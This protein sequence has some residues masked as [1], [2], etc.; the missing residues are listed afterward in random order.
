VGD[1]FTYE[2]KAT[3][4]PDG[5][6]A[7]GLP[8]WLSLN[9]GTGGL[10]ATALKSGTFTFKVS[11]EN[12]AGWGPDFEV[13]L[14]V[15][16]LKSAYRT[17]GP[18]S[19]QGYVNEVLYIIPTRSGASGG[20]YVDARVDDKQFWKF[21]KEW[22][23]SGQRW[24]TLPARTGTTGFYNVFLS[25]SH[26]YGDWRRIS[27]TILS[28]QPALKITSPTVVYARAGEAFTYQLTS[29]VAAASYGF[30]FVGGS[31][32]N[33][34]FDSTTGLVSGTPSLPG[35]YSIL[36]SAFTAVGE[37]GPTSEITLVVNPAVG[38]SSITG[39]TNTGST[40]S[41][42]S[43]SKSLAFGKLTSQSFQLLGG[44]SSGATSG[45]TL[46]ATG[47]VGQAFSYT[48]QASGDV[49]QFDAEGLPPGLVL[50]PNTGEIS[51]QPSLPGD[52]EVTARAWNDAGPGGD[53]VLTITIAAAAGTP[54]VTGTL[55]ATASVDTAFI[56]TITATQSPL[57]FNAANLPPWA[58]LND[59]TGEITGIPDAPGDYE[60]IIS[61]NNAAGI[62]RSRTLALAVHAAAGTPSITS[63]PSAS[64][65]ENAS[66]TIQL[67]ASNS[68][69]LFSADTLPPG[70]LLDQENGLISGVP[71]TQGIYQ[72]HVWAQNAAGTGAAS[73]LTI[74]VG[75][76]A[77]TPLITSAAT[78]MGRVGEAFQFTLTAS[79]NPASFTVGALPDGLAID[80]IT[81]A[82]TGM[83][84]AEGTT[85]VAVR[86]TNGAG[87]GAETT[88]TIDI[89]PA[90][91]S[92]EE[93]ADRN[94]LTPGQ[95]GPT[96]TPFGDGVPNLVRFA[97]GITDA[98]SAPARLPEMKLEEEV[99]GIFPAI[100]FT[101]STDA[102]G[103]ELSLEGGADLSDLQPLDSTLEVVGQV[104][105]TSE[106]V[107]LKQTAP[108][109]GESKWF[110]RLRVR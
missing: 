109:T 29:S 17:D 80:P 34:P 66:L 91:E 39:A 15:S 62:G 5:F 44:A 30:D 81:G 23:Y 51:G 101:R 84:T 35:T 100:E 56:Y 7:T 73:P 90:K 58:S 71:T 60:V 77:G 87:T 103:I 59:E 75:P 96:D 50:N 110:L 55:T 13:T 9:S 22:D 43:A 52:F 16:A 41:G 92:F 19:V 70:L 63:S 82:I 85:S 68:P 2:I 105:A 78:A 42:A 97:L 11:A 106:R 25:Y 27:V 24:K 3:G 54:V 6:R 94:D 47:Q 72:I 79:G 28:R 21:Y 102:G 10:S 18:I 61:A 99:G 93:W 95:D 88:L 74:T 65:A 46:S 89:S 40:N 76:A 69:D 83:P 4:S 53:V 1:P 98:A 38:T 36:A 67:A 14:T 26:D 37:Q 104:D 86:A 20:G 45:A 8:S 31:P 57:G 33:L 12:A 48:L 64:G 108:I 32:G 49:T 107:R